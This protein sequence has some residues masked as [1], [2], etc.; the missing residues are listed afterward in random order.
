MVQNT[1]KVIQEKKKIAKVSQSF[2]SDGVKKIMTLCLVYKHPKI[3]LGMKKR[4]FGAGKWNGFGGKVKEGEEVHEAA[5]RETR[6]EANIDL[7]D[8][9]RVGVLD[10]SWAGKPDILEVNIFRVGDFDGEPK[11]SEEMRPQWFNIEEIPYDQMWPDDK[12]WMPL[13]LSGKSFRG[14]F[15]F[16]DALNILEYN[17]REVNLV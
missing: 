2:L 11:E 14:N 15:I 6:E 12:H 16:D 13:F 5:K 8:L 4:S 10:F 3:L 7:K 1:K 17:L 9:R